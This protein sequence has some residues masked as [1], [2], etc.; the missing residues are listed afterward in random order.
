VRAS[1]SAGVRARG[2]RELAL[3]GQVVGDGL[4]PVRVPSAHL[5]G[6]DFGGRVALQA[7]DRVDELSRDAS[8]LH[9]C[10]GGPELTISPRRAVVPSGPR[11]SRPVDRSSVLG[12]Q[13]LHDQ[14]DRGCWCVRSDLNLAH[15]GRRSPSYSW[16]V[17][18]DACSSTP[19]LR[20]ARLGLAGS[21]G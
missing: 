11:S 4:G 15:G 8:A 6:S 2:A 14:S 16:E 19:V 21:M 5:L 17:A 7:A 18:E 12:C 13:C 9:G 10:V 20:C 3:D 1:E